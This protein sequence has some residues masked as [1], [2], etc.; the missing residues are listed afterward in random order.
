MLNKKMK[1]NIVLAILTVLLV[2]GIVWSG[3]AWVRQNVS[4]QV[5]LDTESARS[6]WIMDLVADF[7]NQKATNPEAASAE[8]YINAGDRFVGRVQCIEL[9]RTEAVK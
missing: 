1:R 9:I 4:K 3:R 6:V 2:S 5:A 7:C 8:F